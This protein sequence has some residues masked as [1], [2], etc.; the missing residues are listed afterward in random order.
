MKSLLT[1]LFAGLALGASAQTKK[2]QITN[3]LAATISH[4]QGSKTVQLLIPGV[5][6]IDLDLTQSPGNTFLIKT[7]DYN[8]DGY[9]DFALTSKDASN[10]AAPTVYDIYIY[11]PQDKTFEAPENP[12]GVCGQFSNI[13]LNAG[14]KTLRSSC[15]T[16][17]KTSLD[18]FRWVTPFSLELTKS[19][20]NSQEAQQE[21]SEEKAEKKQE[22]ADARKEAK[23][24]RAEERENKRDQR[25]T[26]R[27][28]EDDD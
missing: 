4:A 12:G 5:E 21:A 9:K 1:I 15:R 2:L 28:D 7:A 8:F 25:K 11:N 18:I 10:P 17:N 19:T 16:G 27:D 14:D 26:T 22:K 24:D 13:R 20:D 3:G 6:A 23:E